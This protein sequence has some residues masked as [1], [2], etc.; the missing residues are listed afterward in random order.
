MLPARSSACE[1]AAL[2]PV[3]PVAPY[4]SEGGKVA[5]GSPA[6]SAQ[7]RSG[8]IGQLSIHGEAAA[9]GLGSLLRP[10]RALA[11]RRLIAA[12]RNGAKPAVRYQ[13]HPETGFAAGAPSPRPKDTPDSVA[14]A[15][16]RPFDASF[17]RRFLP[18]ALLSRATHQR[19]AAHALAFARA[20]RSAEA[21][22][23]PRDDRFAGRRPPKR[24]R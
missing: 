1:E 21:P 12:A 2:L 4:L 14:L 8:P 3:G 15:P 5:A 9:T 23:C 16:P 17:L 6:A 7:I 18:V 19:L 20:T 11:E 13:K 10:P 22:R 24:G